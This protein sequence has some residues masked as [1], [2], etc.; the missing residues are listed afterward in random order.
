MLIKMNKKLALGVLIVALVFVLAGCGKQTTTNQPTTNQPTT[1][2]TTT[3]KVPGVTADS[4]SLAAIGDITGPTA[5]TQASFFEGIKDSAKFINE[6]GGVNGRKFN[7]TVEDDQYKV[8]KAVTIFKRLIENGTFAIM[9][10]GGNNQ[11]VALEPNI[12]DEKIP[13]FGPMSASEIQQKNPYTFDM[14]LSMASMAK[15]LVQRVL[16]TY[17]GTGKPKIAVFFY[18]IAIGYEF[19][20]AFLEIAKEGKVDFVIMDP[21]PVGVKDAASQVI[22][23]K[24]AKADFTIM[25]TSADFYMAY[26]RDAQKNGISDI[27]ALVTSG[28]VT[29]VVWETVGKEA[30]K[31]YVGMQSYNPYYAQGSGPEQLRQFAEKHNVSKQNLDNLSYVQGWTTGIVFAEAVKRA[32]KDLT[33]EGLIKAIEGLKDFDTGGLSG[34]ISF[35]PGQHGGIQSARFYT[36]NFD[37]KRLEPASDVMKIQ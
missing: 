25:H 9:G 18:D 26:L 16:A 30:S 21:V 20:Q 31:N 17:K 36:Y 5:S 12:K 34:P 13:W 22:K 27:Q 19:K 14:N 7:L 37:T 3:A 24:N 10:Q 4:I 15:I 1:N 33:R 23:V 11:Y 6:N 35:G 32:G 29:P 2:Q 8:E 28:G